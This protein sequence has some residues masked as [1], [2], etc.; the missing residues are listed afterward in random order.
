MYHTFISVYSEDEKE[1]KK[2]YIY[3]YVDIFL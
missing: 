2:K 3:I 1:N